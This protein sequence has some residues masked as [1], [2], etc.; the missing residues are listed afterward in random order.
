MFYHFITVMATN[1]LINRFYTSLVM[2]VCCNGTESDELGSNF[3]VFLV[4]VVQMFT[5]FSPIFS[6]A[7]MK[8][9]FS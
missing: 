3:L 2:S 6:L 4:N 7:F 5:I 1:W 9:L 8:R